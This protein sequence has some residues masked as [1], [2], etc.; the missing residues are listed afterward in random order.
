MKKKK[1]ILPIILSTSFAL[2]LIVSS[3]GN[4]VAKTDTNK[5]DELNGTKTPGETDKEKENKEN[6]ALYDEKVKLIE[7]TFN[8]Q[9]TKDE[10]KGQLLQLKISNKWQEVK[11]FGLKVQ[12]ALSKIKNDLKNN[13]KEFLHSN[14]QEKWFVKLEAL[15]SQNEIAQFENDLKADVN[16]ADANSFNNKKEE[17]KNLINTFSN[18]SRKKTYLVKLEEMTTYYDLLY[19]ARE[20]SGAKA[21][22]DQEKALLDQKELFNIKNKLN[23]YLSIL[24]E[25]E[26]VKISKELL[27]NK[28]VEEY[29]QI[30][31]KIKS[32]NSNPNEQQISAFKAKLLLV[33]E[34]ISKKTDKEKV[35]TAIE[36]ANKNFAQ[37]ENVLDNNL[38]PELKK[39]A[40]KIKKDALKWVNELVDNP[41][42]DIATKEIAVGYEFLLNSLYDIDTLNALLEQIRTQARSF[43]PFIILKPYVSPVKTDQNNYQDKKQIANLEVIFPA[44]YYS[45]S[46]VDDVS[47]TKTNEVGVR[48]NTSK[49]SFYISNLKPPLIRTFTLSEKDREIQEKLLSLKQRIIKNFYTLASKTTFGEQPKKYE[50]YDFKNQ[51]EEAS[52]KIYKLRISRLLFSIEKALIE[53][54]F[55]QEVYETLSGFWYQS[56]DEV[57]QAMPL[58]EL[59]TKDTNGLWNFNELDTFIKKSS[60]SANNSS[61][62]ALI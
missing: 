32:D 49:D 40:D 42:V 59:L 51:L 20:M 1:V 16:S 50:T 15:K 27:E 8:D 12:E 58:V 44:S 34:Q 37:L 39:R 4:T 7:S 45:Y 29:Q 21:V 46:K 6:E 17:I 53:G 47:N 10:L 48:V 38:L 3:C 55:Y 41:N 22:D 35:V 28:S 14:Y 36:N 57:E 54:Y 2:P 61:T 19:F 11:D 56:G 60:S 13:L 25:S 62:S 30:L 24:S 26:Q 43:K 31:N 9:F 18:E 5:P 52:F 33:S 23:I